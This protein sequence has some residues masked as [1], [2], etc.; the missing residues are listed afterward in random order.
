MWPASSSYPS[1]QPQY[2]LVISIA[3]SIK[4]ILFLLEFATSMS[5]PKSLFD[6]LSSKYWQLLSFSLSL[7]LKD[8]HPVLT[9]RNYLLFIVQ[10]FLLFP[11]K[12]HLEAHLHQEFYHDGKESGEEVFLSKAKYRPAPFISILHYL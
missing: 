8:F 7:S 3:F 6:L 4:F 11:I 1:F 2:S 5:D 10:I 12:T 9:C